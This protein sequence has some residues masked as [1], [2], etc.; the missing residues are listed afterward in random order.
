M[1]DRSYLISVKFTFNLLNNGATT[2]VRYY[3]KIEC[4]W[5]NHSVFEESILE[6]KRKK[7]EKESERDNIETYLSSYAI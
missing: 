3:S 1:I 4:L 5:K 6:A 7:K 2:L